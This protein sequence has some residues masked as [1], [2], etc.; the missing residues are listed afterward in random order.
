MQSVS[1]FY[2][3]YTVLVRVLAMALVCLSVTS[4][5][6]VDMAKRIGLVLVFGMGLLSTCPTLYGKEI[7]LP[8]KKCTSPWNFAHNSELRKFFHGISI[9]ETCCQLS[10]RKVVIRKCDKLDRRWSTKL[11]I[12]PI[13]DARPL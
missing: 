13:S 1:D 7:R 6:S 4:R 3:H 8:Q 12:A 11:T 5:S 9:V 10:S 2:L